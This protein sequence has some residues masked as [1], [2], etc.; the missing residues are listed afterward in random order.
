MSNITDKYLGRAD[1]SVN[2]F[3][4]TLESFGVSSAPGAQFTATYSAGNK[5]VA[6][7][8]SRQALSNPYLTL[9]IQTASG[10]IGSVVNIIS[11]GPDASGKEQFQAGVTGF[12]GTV[13]GDSIAAVTAKA[14]TTAGI[15]GAEVIG[16][17]VIV[18]VG[19]GAYLTTAINEFFD[20]IPH[21]DGTTLHT[22]HDIYGEYTLNT[23][24][25]L[26]DML[27]ESLYEKIFLH[28]DKDLKEIYENGHSFTLGA[29]ENAEA[30]F[31]YD[32]EDN[33]VKY[34]GTFAQAQEISGN[35]KTDISAMA[36][37]FDKREFLLETTTGIYKVHS[38]DDLSV[39]ELVALAKEDKY[40]FSA[41]MHLTK[42]NYIVSEY[43]VGINY[44]ERVH[45]YS[46]EFLEQRAKFVKELTLDSNPYS[47]TSDHASYI[48]EN[49]NTVRTK[50]GMNVGVSTSFGDSTDK[51]DGKYVKLNLF[52]GEEAN[53]IKG[54]DSK[55]YVEGLGGSDTIY[56]YGGDDII[57]T[58]ANI[59]DS[60][61]FENAS[62]TNTV[63]AGDG[64]DKVY[65]SNGIDIVYGGE[66]ADII[67]GGGGDDKLYSYRKEGKEG[68]RDDRDKDILRGGTGNDELH[69]G[70]GGDILEG[71]KDY[72]TYYAVDKNII[73]DSDG[74]G[75]IHF[76]DKI[77]GASGEI[78]FKG[79]IPSSPGMKSLSMALYTDGKF[80]YYM[81][82]E[83][84]TLMVTDIQSGESITVKNF[85]SGD[86]G[87]TLGKKEIGKCDASEKGVVLEGNSTKTKSSDVPLEKNSY[88][89]N[90]EPPY[91]MPKSNESA[92]EAQKN[93]V[94]KQG[95]VLMDNSTKPEHEVENMEQD[96]NKF[97]MEN[98]ELINE[99]LKNSNHTPQDNSMD[100][101]RE[102][103][104]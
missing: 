20:Y 61:D 99:I 71:G 65:G 6:E 104:D 58:N 21:M 26:Q 60:H 18:A 88:D 78:H 75:E 47:H 35:A 32:A 87:I 95:V 36:S 43:P 31:S 57:Y 9:K 64:K 81:V 55:D 74:L 24:W 17:E 49:L 90:A 66:G 89:K 11:L 92:Q 23:D 34:N 40:V 28:G 82:K 84:S 91:P 41:L 72:D 38:I 48:D 19:A 62:I 76:K 69:G 59:R 102:I 33:I 5:A 30:F 94:E 80:N 45:Q 29:I 97:I 8:L 85:H 22:S 10:A 46:N 96:L 1:H 50:E 73:E 70:R 4:K 93:N 14:L 27:N 16:V 39:T 77:L 86:L 101:G 63:Y 37:F 67:E 98:P 68:Q 7:E 3:V 12:S 100:H 52:G 56:T 83:N 103:G 54:S 25:S 44:D 42:D 51:H 53:T 13:L 15:A 79:E 2:N